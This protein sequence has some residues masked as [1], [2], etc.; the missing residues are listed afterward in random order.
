MVVRACLRGPH[1][2]HSSSVKT[3]GSAGAVVG[4]GSLLRGPFF[5]SAVRKPFFIE[6]QPPRGDEVEGRRLQGTTL[7]GIGLLLDRASQQ[8]GVAAL[9]EGTARSHSELGNLASL[10]E[11]LKGLTA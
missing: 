7:L 6:S 5:G 2:A 4:V 11:Y 3:E 9:A 10:R 1:A 8:P